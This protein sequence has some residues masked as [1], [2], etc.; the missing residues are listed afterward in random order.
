MKR[1]ALI[2]LLLAACA[3]VPAA[4]ERTAIR[5]VLDQQ[6]AAWNRG[7]LEAY[8]AGY[9]RGD[10]LTFF[11]GANVTHGWQPTL[12]RYRKRY[13]GEGKEMGTLTFSDVKIDV[14]A[15]DAAFV[16]GAWHLAMK[17]GESPHGL[18]TLLMRKTDVGW[19]IVHDHSS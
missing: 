18:F 2:A 11:S 6:V 10:E 16:R 4:D 5:Q 15:H 19:R 9:T 3:T 13:Q 1:V 12:D 17:Q 7:D 8:M 14:V